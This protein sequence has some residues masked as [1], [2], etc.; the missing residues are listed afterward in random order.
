M[1]RSRG[2][3]FTDNECLEN[4]WRD[5]D[6]TYVL[7]GREVAPSTLQPHLQ[8]FIYFG[9]KKSL[10]QM[11]AIHP[12]CHWEV[13]R[14]ASNSVIY[15]KKDGDFIERG[16][17]PAQG[18][19]NDLDS[20]YSL[21][22]SGATLR[23]V[24]D[25]HPSVFLKYTQGV[26]C[27]VHL[28]IEH[29]DQEIVPNVR[30]YYG[31]TGAGKS[32]RAFEEAGPDAYVYSA[33]GKFWEGY[34]GQT[35]VILDDFR[36]D[37]IPFAILLRVLD[38]YRFTVETKGSSCPLAATEFWIT[39]P[40]SPRDTYTGTNHETGSTWEK[41]NIDQLVRR[42]THIENFDTLANILMNHKPYADCFTNCK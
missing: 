11:K 42:C 41:E 4:V 39:S 6:C 32:R 24:A 31:S 35:R 8:G 17:P 34:S 38:R 1:S 3:C 12:G 19:R 16:V 37:N 40:K 2:W 25:A 26:K 10:N 9:T 27:A 23:E 7:Y 21:I 33:T 15:C 5:V 30:W 29:R 14:S 18:T 28:Q 20:A 22:Q 36:P 13:A